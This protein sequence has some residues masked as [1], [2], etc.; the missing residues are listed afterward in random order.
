MTCTRCETGTAGPS[1]WCKPCEVTYD[2]W[3]RQYAADIVWQVLAG[4]VVV[5]GFGMGLPLLGVS[6]LVAALG[7]F[8]GFGT[9]VGLHR[10]N[11]RR[12]RR[13]FLTANLP[14]MYLPSSPD[15]RR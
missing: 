10:L 14:R 4:T 15:P 9:L 7:V 13:Q 8:A 6:W 5:V 11:R 3:S 12:R 1:G 2:A